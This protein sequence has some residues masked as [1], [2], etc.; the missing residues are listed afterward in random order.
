MPARGHRGVAWRPAAWLAGIAGLLLCLVLALAW[1]GSA[2]GLSWLLQRPWLVAHGGLRVEHLRG[3]VWSGELR[4]R[5]LEWRADASSV[6]ARRV[7]LRWRPERLLSLSPSLLVRELDIGE[8]DL[9]RSAA[10]SSASVT[11]RAAATLRLAPPLSLRVDRLRIGRLRLQQG[12]ARA[13]WRDLGWLHGSL[14][15][16]ARRWQLALVWRGPHGL[17]RAHA[18]V[19]AQPPYALHAELGGEW[20]VQQHTLQLHAHVGGTLRSL[21]LQARAQA[22]QAQA[23]LDARLHPFDAQWLGPTQLRLRGLDPRRLQPGWP[24]AQLD[25]QAELREAAHG[26]LQASLCLRNAQAGAVDAARLPLREL[27]AALALRAGVLRVDSLH[28]LL[29]GG[30]QID[31]SAQWA[32]HGGADARLRVHALDLRALFARLVSTRLDGRLAWHAGADGQRLRARLQQPGWNIALQARRQGARMVLQQALVQ[33]QGASLRL[34]G[35]VE[36]SGAQAFRVDARL[37]DF[38]PNRFGDWPQARLNL[39]LRAHGALRQRQAEFALR[40]QPSVWRGHRFE[41]QASGL[42]SPAGVRDLRADLRLGD[43]R[44][45]VRGGLGE[46]AT[47]LELRL[48]APA[49]AQLGAA[50]GGSLQ[51]SASVHGGI[52]TASGDARLRARDLHV[53]G[54]LRLAQLDATATLQQGRHGR[55]ALQAGARGVRAAGLQLSDLELHAA[56]TLRSHVLELRAADGRQLRLHLRAQGGWRAGA[57]WRGLVDTLDNPASYG[58]HLEHPAHLRIA[59]DGDIR[60]RDL[61]LR[62]SAGSLDLQSLQR[63]GAAW[64]SRGTASDVAVLPW[65][66]LAGLA[67]HG[68]RSDLRLQAQWQL[69]TGATPQLRLRVARSAGDLRLPG[70]DAPA[71]GLSQLLVRV[72]VDAGQARAELDAAG[73]R[74][75]V[76][77]AQVDAMLRHGMRG[78][79]LAGTAP[80]R[81]AASLRLP[82]ISWVSALLPQAARVAGRLQ[83]AVQLS[84]TPAA[85]HLQGSLDGS[86]LAVLLPGLGLDLRDGSV[87]ASFA[88]DR[89][90]LQ[91]LVLHGADGGVVRGSGGFVLADGKPDGSLQLRLEGLQALDR[92]GQQLR[93]SGDAGLRA[94]AGQLRLDASLRVDKAQFELAGAAAAQLAPDVVVQGRQAPTPAR[95]AMPLQ[96]LL[97]VDLGQHFHVTG[98]GV[99]ARLGGS[100]LVRAAPGQALRADG[101]VIVRSGTYGAYGQSLQLV[102]GGSVNFSG[103]VGNPGLNLA[104]Q[105]E[106]LPVQV[107]VSIQGTLRA[108]QVRLTSTPS[109]P[110]SAILSWLVLGQDPSTVAADQT[111]LLQA[112]G[113]ALL[114]R[115]QSASGTARLAGALG[116][117]QLSVSGEGGLQNSVVTVG[118]K[119]SSRLSVSIE[120]GLSGAASLFNVRY[121][122]SHR[123]SLRLQSGTDNAIDVFY[124]FSFD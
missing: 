91:A 65:A 2:P 40:V 53:P 88:G 99:D 3:S 27:R 106:G 75:G 73:S 56:G 110:D 89:L 59:P 72:D 45:F 58:L 82:D 46:A 113:A 20:Q 98:Y 90:S 26:A 42:A 119:L 32:L 8:L 64:S 118:K 60:V 86:A 19:A 100:L 31:G 16:D 68:V 111:S 41:G 1:L 92:P 35:S 101:S 114:S 4:A 123:L 117:D 28:A 18:G 21:L 34:H 36:P 97:H 84:G 77:H 96:A 24:Q 54:G 50:W 67:L 55:L 70:G 115:G 95:A 108:P 122:L 29:S 71:L 51:A 80:L 30:G 11:S 76:L 112:A 22:V 48:Q 74:L 105:R 121:A 10:S 39:G 102:R 12:D 13:P 104:A 17:L 69:R 85:P 83:C 49:L 14:R 47:R 124:T 63:R 23:S 25:A 107:G 103:P 62:S 44:L 7:R 93:L 15:G 79:A 6:E 43:N 38:Q 116:L 87:A 94:S 9:R 81:G 57:G 61:S 33:A 109:M 66:R 52:A 78:W 37:R 5:R 120:R